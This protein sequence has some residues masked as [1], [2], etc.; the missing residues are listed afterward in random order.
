MPCAEGKWCLS[1]SG[2]IGFIPYPL[3]GSVRS[4]DD[5]C[6]MVCITAHYFLILYVKLAGTKACIEYFYLYLLASACKV[7]MQLQAEIKK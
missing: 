6:Q 7:M 3:A 4:T 5:I 1:N 2:G